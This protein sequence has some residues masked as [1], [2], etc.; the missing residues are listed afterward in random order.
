MTA[1]D[2]DVGPRG[3]VELAAFTASG[4]RV[5]EQTLSIAAYY[6]ELHPIID[7]A[8]EFR[9]QRLIRRVA[10]RIYGFDGELDQDFENEYDVNG[11]Y[12]RGRIIFSDGTIVEN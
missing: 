2:D 11:S 9:A 10:G 4:D 8:G 3:V 7:D 1:R 6:E 5:M 12:V